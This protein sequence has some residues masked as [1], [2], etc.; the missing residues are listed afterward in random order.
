MEQTNQ[1]IKATWGVA[2][3]ISW[4]IWWRSFLSL[5]V[6]G[7][8]LGL[9][10]GIARIDKDTIEIISTIFGGIMGFVIS[11]FFIKKIIGKKF[12]D[13]SLVLV[14]TDKSE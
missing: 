12:K 8:I 4:W 9:F 10:L 7:F 5:F 14:K 2:L 1:T 11:I 6:F 13:F 3:K